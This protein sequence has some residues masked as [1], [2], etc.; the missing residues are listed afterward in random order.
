MGSTFVPL[1]SWVYPALRR[2][3]ALGYI[4][5]QTSDLAPWTRIECTHQVA[6]AGD[7]VNE[8]SLAQTDSPV[9]EEALRLLADL[10]NEFPEDAA[11]RD[12][13]VTLES[14]YTRLTGIGSTPL[15][16]SYHF[17]Q[18]VSND[19]G[20]RYQKG[21]NN[22]TGFSGYGHSGVLFAYLRGEYQYAPGRDAYDFKLRRFIAGTD[23]NPVLPGNPIAS[24][25][26]F[27]ALEAYVGAQIGFENVSFGKESLWWGPGEASAF[28]FSNNAEPFYML[29]FTQSRP[30]VLPSLLKHLGKIRTQFI[31]G[32]L[33]GHHWPARPLVNAQ[34]V[35]LDLTENFELGF[36]RS[37]FWGGVGHPITKRSFYESLFSTAS[38]GTYRYG[39]HTDPGD[40][41]SG[42]DFRWRIPKLRRYVSIYSDSYADDDPNPLAN[43]RRSAWGPGIYISHLPHA[44]KLDL[45]FET[46]STLLYS[47][48]KGGNFIYWNNQYHDA[49]TNTGNVLGSWVG[50]DAR[51]YVGSAGYW[52][53]ARSRIQG[54]YRQIKQSAVYLPGGG[55][56]TDGSVFVQ[57]GL[58]PELLINGSFQYERYDIPV[59]SRLVHNDALASI[60]ITYT[61]KNV[62]YTPKSAS[63]N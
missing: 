20:R 45:R 23:E 60:Q 62:T 56:Q 9:L 24:T 34:K 6:E 43:P 3:A 11:E 40:R 57:W 63:L 37:S 28:S 30:I 44:S 33:S 53:S 49:Y 4:P 54:E 2:L 19:F 51:A 42:F 36:T 50:R 12:K 58:T 29:N 18:T 25:N 32:E 38:S 46:Y 61:P 13:A 5:D 16:D 7:L 8:S 10:Q 26:R 48:D 21:I 55:T 39:D 59:L 52:L 41:H 35:T 22:V 14:V 1:D 47:G 15:A 31:F 17:G 27:D